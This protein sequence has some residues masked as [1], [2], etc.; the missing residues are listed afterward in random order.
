[1]M[2]EHLGR[3][4]DLAERLQR[5]TVGAPMRDTLSE[6]W[7]TAKEAEYYRQLYEELTP[8]EH[9]ASSYIANRSVQSQTGIENIGVIGSSQ[10]D[11]PGDLGARTST[12]R[13]STSGDSHT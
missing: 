3:A 7:Y 8:R 1:M 9:K 13:P 2:I 4:K 5:V 12:M 6:I 10:R 11:P